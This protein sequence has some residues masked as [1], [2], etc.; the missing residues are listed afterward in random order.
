MAADRPFD[1]AEFLER[2]NR[3]EF[4]GRVHQEIRKLSQEQL[5]QIA[6]LMAKHLKEKKK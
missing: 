4:D 6:L 3:G 5:E 2:L 1:A